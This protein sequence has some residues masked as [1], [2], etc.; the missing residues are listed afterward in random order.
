ME[1]SRPALRRRCQ[2]LRANLS[3]KYQQRASLKVCE[4]IRGLEQYQQ[5]KHVAVYQASDGEI[6]LESLWKSAEEEKFY[7]FPVVVENKKLLFLPAKASTPFSKNRYGIEEPEVPRSQA[8]AANDLDLIFLPLVAF[9]DFGT[10]LGRGAGYYDRS[11]ADI[12]HPLLIGLAYEFQ[13]LSYIEPASWDV[14]LSGVITPNTIY[15][16]KKA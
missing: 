4:R 1:D 11:L 3:S 12:A 15:W 7:Y 16:S 13:H 8:V 10:R 14:P 5:A 9:D 6:S 2:Q